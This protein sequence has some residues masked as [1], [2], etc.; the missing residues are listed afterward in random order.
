ME[1]DE[2]SKELPNEDK[3]ENSDTENDPV[4]FSDEL[5]QNVVSYL[6]LDDIMTKKK[7]DIK[8]LKNKQSKNEEKIIE[9]FDSVKIEFIKT[10]NGTINRNTVNKP[11]PITIAII[12][13]AL[14]IMAT[15]DNNVISLTN[16]IIDTSVA[17]INEKIQIPSESKAKKTTNH[18]RNFN[19][20]NFIV[21]HY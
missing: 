5:K 20:G 15:E 17:L 11:E 13:K 10:R 1:L 8:E 7:D 4:N 12:K 9:Y 14:S 3:S 21:G 2:L 19:Q 16:K 18:N 6:K